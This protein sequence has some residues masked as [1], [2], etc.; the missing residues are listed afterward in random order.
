MRVAY[1]TGGTAGAGHVVRGIA[2]GR[3]LERAGFD[4]NYRL[5]VPVTPM[6]GIL[7]AAKP[8]VPTVCPVESHEVLDPARAPGSKLAASL[9]DY[10]PDLLL[11]DLFWAPMLHI[12]PLL[13]CE[14]WLIVRNCP[15]AW[16]RGTQNIRFDPTQYARVIEIE[17]VGHPEIRERIEPVV[18]CNPDESRSRDD[19][20]ARWNIGNEKKIYVISHAGLDGENDEFEADAETQDDIYVIRSDLHDPD[21]TFPLAIWLPAVDRVYCAAG[22]N[23]YWESR[24]MNYAHKTRLRVFGRKIDDPLNRV[25]AGRDYQMKANGADTLARSIT[26]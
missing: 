24:W 5:F 23:S 3:A 1:F 9:V 7:R 20:C 22:Y 12:L 13:H 14:A 8:Y 25:N 15:P 2:I 4:G 6:A 21:S 18:I 11:V 19:V 26:G 16:L 17:P 10:A